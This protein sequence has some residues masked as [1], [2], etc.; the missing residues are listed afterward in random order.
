MGT[1]TNYIPSKH[2]MKSYITP[3]AVAVISSGVSAINLNQ[4]NLQNLA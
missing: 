4:E 2:L 1:K 3:L